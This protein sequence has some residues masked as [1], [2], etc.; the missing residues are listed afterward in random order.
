M[1]TPLLRFVG[2]FRGSEAATVREA[3]K[4]A[5]QPVAARIKSGPL[6][7]CWRYQAGARQVDVFRL[8]RG[9]VLQFRV[10]I[11]PGWP[12]DFVKG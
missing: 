6:K 9:F 5:P 10:V 11:R 7:G 4:T 2:C 3:I 8:G 12:E 1:K